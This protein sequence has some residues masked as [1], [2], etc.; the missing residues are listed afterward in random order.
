MSQNN[1]D[2][3][4]HTFVCICP[5]G[6]KVSDGVSEDGPVVP[7]GATAGV[8]ALLLHL[9]IVQ[10]TQLRDQLPHCRPIAI[11]WDLRRAKEQNKW[12]CCKYYS[13]DILKLFTHIENENRL[14]MVHETRVIGCLLI[15]NGTEATFTALRKNKE[16]TSG[17]RLVIS[18][19]IHI[20]KLQ[21]Y[22][23]GWF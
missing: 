11:V 18:I 10:V 2:K 3:H 17:F 13:L 12:V 6:V 7:R 5:R 22:Q 19:K 21:V 20:Y 4:T 15:S 14:L 8:M 9:H 23:W 1:M 16:A